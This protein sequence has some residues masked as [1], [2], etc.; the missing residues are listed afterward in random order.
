[1]QTIS[2]ILKIVYCLFMLKEFTFQPAL[3]VDLGLFLYIF[4]YHQSSMAPTG[5]MSNPRALHDASP[6]YIYVFQFR[7]LFRSIKI[8]NIIMIL[9]SED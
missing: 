5:R 9:E 6:L 8:N 7:H 4:H 3:S 1:M 2:S